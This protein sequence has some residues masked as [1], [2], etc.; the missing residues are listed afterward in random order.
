MQDCTV[1]DV[2]KPLLLVNN[3]DGSFGAGIPAK[4]AA[5][6]DY[7]GFFND[8]RLFFTP[9]S[10]YKLPELKAAFLNAFA[11]A[12]AFLQIND[13][14]NHGM[15]FVGRAD[16]SCY[17][18]AF[19]RSAFAIHSAHC[20]K[21]FCKSQGIAPLRILE[22]KIKDCSRVIFFSNGFER[23]GQS[24]LKMAAKYFPDSRNLSVNLG[25]LFLI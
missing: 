10:L 22:K 6:A 24:F 12:A 23:A 20:F 11:A 7:S 25:L 2:E 16:A 14:L 15:S 9:F 13:M 4:A 8:A 19:I 17:W 5:V 1:N 3:N 18:P 21:N